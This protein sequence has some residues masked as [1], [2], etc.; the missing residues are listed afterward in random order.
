[1]AHEGSPLWAK[2]LPLDEALHRFTVG[3]D[4]VTDL[5]LLPWDIVGSAAHARTLAEGGFLTVPDAA[6]LLEALKVLHGEALAGRIRIT[7]A[8]EDGHTALE[9]ALVERCGEAGKRIHLGRSRN[10][11]VILALRLLYRDELAQ[12]GEQVA[13][14]AAAFLALAERHPRTPMPGYTHLRRAMP[15]SWGL[16]GAAFAEGLLEELEA[17]GGLL[18]RLDR[19]PSGAAAGFGAPLPL[20]RARTAALLGFSRVQGNPIDVMNSRGRHEGAIADWLASV[21][22]VLEKAFWDLAIFSMEEV[23]FV[24]LPDAFTTGSS[25]MP[26]KRNPDAVELAR[27]TCRHL[28]GQAGLVHEL[29]GGLPSSYHR[30][31]QLLKAP[32]L[33]MLRRASKLFAVLP[34]LIE[35]L[36]IDPLR[37]EGACGGELHAAHAATALAIGGMPFREAYREVAHRILEGTFMPDQSAGC[38]AHPADTATPGARLR[39]Q[40]NSLQALREGWGAALDQLWE[41][42]STG[43]SSRHQENP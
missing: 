39:E 7:P 29:S 15:S 37:C 35:G 2:D 20:D 38:G 24:A 25:I 1:M 6:S 17:L 32:V 41:T 31:L 23:G 36:I 22:S 3:E 21:A 5:A 43:P 13:L 11:Q 30:D 19:C 18:H 10:D 26:Q 27:A 34:S 14:I 33:D 4:P 42:P 28:R 9:L 12:L 16:W 40:R 8:M